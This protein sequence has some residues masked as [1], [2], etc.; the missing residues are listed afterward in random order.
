M[1]ANGKAEPID[2]T[3]LLTVKGVTGHIFAVRTV[4]VGDRYGRE[5]CQV[6]DAETMVEFYDR[7]YIDFDSWSGALGQFVC[8][9]YLSSLL[10]MRDIASPD[11]MGLNLYVSVPAWAIDGPELAELLRTIVQREELLAQIKEAN[12]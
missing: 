7:T 1:K 8:R 9:Y 10:Y 12:K 6:N 11:C 3:P 4:Y 2:P 5:G